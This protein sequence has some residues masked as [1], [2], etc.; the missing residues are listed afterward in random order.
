M[1]KI[2]LFIALFLTFAP[3]SHG[4]C[5][6]KST[7]P[8]GSIEERMPGY[9]PEQLTTQPRFMVGNIEFFARYIQPKIVEPMSIDGQATTVFIV[10]ETGKV[11]EI[12]VTECSS[13]MLAKRIVRA[14]RKSPDWTPG[15]VNGEPVRTRITLPLKFKR[16][17]GAV[18]TIRQVRSEVRV[19]GED[20]FRQMQQ[21]GV[22]RGKS[23]SPDEVR[24]LQRSGMIPH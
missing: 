14:I 10:D 2:I 15:T 3:L 21:D 4:A 9:T 1:K 6:P 22:P 17:G 8:E 5:K 16:A 11:A 23:L 13:K 12:E 20:E 19:I 7:V 18:Q 24:E